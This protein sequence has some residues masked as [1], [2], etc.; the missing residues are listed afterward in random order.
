MDIKKILGESEII[1]SQYTKTGKFYIHNKRI[2]MELVTSTNNVWFDEEITNQL[3]VE[4]FKELEQDVREFFNG[5]VRNVSS[6]SLNKIADDLFL[7][8]DEALEAI[9][10]ESE[11]ASLLKV[12]EFFKKNY[13]R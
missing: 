5:K 4:E 10:S 11:K 13:G 1:K 12:I 3:T 2:V 9:E 7:E 8:F 6:L